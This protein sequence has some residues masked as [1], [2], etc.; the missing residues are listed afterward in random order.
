M[1]NT[2]PPEKVPGD[3]SVTA[4]L[5]DDRTRKPLL[6]KG[7]HVNLWETTGDREGVPCTS[8]VRRLAG[9]GEDMGT[10]GSR[11]Q[12]GC[13]VMWRSLS[14]ALSKVGSSQLLVSLALFLLVLLPI[15]SLHFCSSVV[16]P[17]LPYVLSPRHV[18]QFFRIFYFLLNSRMFESLMSA[19]WITVEMIVSKARMCAHT[20]VLFQCY[21][22]QGIRNPFLSIPGKL[23]D[24]PWHWVKAMHWWSTEGYLSIQ[25]WVTDTVRDM[26][27]HSQ[28]TAGRQVQGS[29]SHLSQLYLT[30]ASQVMAWKEI[31]RNIK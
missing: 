19:F 27:K 24:K 10:D 14:F 23:P 3:D 16:K 31:P 21:L 1:D 7:K 28:S 4:A 30:K 8:L 18:I 11:W 22:Q 26:D 25:K 29:I 5:T 2:G 12:N 15:V 13:T 20:A 6:D 17:H 9:T